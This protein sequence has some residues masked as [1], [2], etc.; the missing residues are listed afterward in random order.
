MKIDDEEEEEVMQQIRFKATELLLREE[1]K[2]SI[3]VYTQFISL[4]KNHLSKIT[5]KSENPDR[6]NKLQKTLCLALSNR[7]EAK[8]K[9]RHFAESLEDCNAALEIEKTHFKTLVCKGKI[10]LH[11]NQYA[12]ASNCFQSGLHDNDSIQ[13][14][15]IEMINGFLNRCKKLEYQSRTGVFD[16]SDWVIN[17]FSKDQNPDLAEFTGPIEIKKSEVSGRGLFTTK[18]VEAGNLLFV[19]KA[20]AT[21]RGIFLPECGEDSKMVMW[22]DFVEK[23]V[24]VSTKCRKTY[25]LICRLSTG[26][27]EEVLQ[28]PAISVFRPDSDEFL[29]CEDMKPDVAKILNILDVNSLTEEDGISA[30]VLGKNSDYYGVGLWILASFIN[31]SCEPNARR[32]HVGDHLLVHASRDIKAGE[33]I[34]FGYFDVLTPLSKRNEMSKT[35]GFHCQC[36]R[37]RFERDMYNRNQG[38]NEIEILLECGSD[39]GN[40]IVRLEEGMK[41]WML[42]GEKREKGYLRASFWRVFS[43]AYQSEKSMQRWGRRIPPAEVVGESV[44]E[45]VGSDE[46]VLKMVV[47]GLR[48]N[49]VSSGIVEMEKEMKLGRSV[50]GKV[51]KKRKAVKA[52]LELCIC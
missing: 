2:E 32:L 50:Y 34:L 10:L 52:L 8:S 1:Y 37:C 15:D 47:E 20:V 41:R 13:N 46:R 25:D 29:S 18:N 5:S 39:I 48:K 24:D 23:V 30:K 38:L 45:A 43:E 27:E 12:N 17:G 26:E 31:H 33:E 14:S 22:K 40:V 28:V 42:K 3:Q 7:A 4:S 6:F 19:T 44:A 51:I 9:I 16:L 35:W 36:N 11:L 49:G 21:D